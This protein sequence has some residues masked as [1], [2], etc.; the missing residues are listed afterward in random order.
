MPAT[1]AQATAATTTAAAR[2]RRNTTCTGPVSAP[3]LRLLPPKWVG[4]GQ[5]DR[6]EQLDFVL[7][8]DV[9]ALAYEAPCERDQ[10]RDVGRAGVAEVLDE[11]RVDRR[12]ARAADDVALELTGL[13]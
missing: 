5:A 7:Q 8:L 2:R 9:E 13:D 3:L 1:S 4:S 6:P 12:D 11:V 10:G